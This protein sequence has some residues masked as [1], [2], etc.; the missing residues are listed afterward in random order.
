[1]KSLLGLLF[2]ALLIATALFVGLNVSL[3]NNTNKK[4]NNRIIKYL[5]S[6]MCNI[7]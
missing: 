7:L 6:I 5:F 2:V 4:S 3:F 1:M